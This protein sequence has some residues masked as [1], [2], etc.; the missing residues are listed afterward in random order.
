MFVKK[1]KEFSCT[2]QVQKDKK[3]VDA[4][5]MFALMGLGIKSGETITVTLDGRGEAAAAEE[6]EAFM[7]ENL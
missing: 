4:R 7:R 3:I 2:V 6:L 5:K 1:V